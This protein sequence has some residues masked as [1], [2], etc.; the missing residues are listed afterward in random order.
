[1]CTIAKLYRF[2]QAILNYVEELVLAIDLLGV[3]TFFIKDWKLSSATLAINPINT[4]QAVEYIQQLV[5][6]LLPDMSMYCYVSTVSSQMYNCPCMN[7]ELFAFKF[8]IS[9]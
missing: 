3:K 4:T 8:V 7:I 2:K 6:E 5:E 9:T 1:M